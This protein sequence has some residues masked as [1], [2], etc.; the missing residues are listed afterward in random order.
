[1]FGK[2]ERNKNNKSEENVN[3]PDEKSATS[4]I[5][6]EETVNIE[7]LKQKLSVNTDI[8]FN[9][10]IIDADRKFSVVF[11]DGM[12]NSQ[13]V[14]DSILKPLIQEDTLKETE[15]EQDLINLIMLGTVYHCQRKKRD[16]LS[17]CLSD[18]LTGSAV[19]VFEESKTAVTFEIKGFEKRGLSEPTNENVLKGAKE[20]FIEVLR[21]NTA[22]V[23]RRIPTSSL[24]IKQMSI[25]KRTNTA[26]SII[27]LDGLANQS[28]VD[29]VKKRLEKIDID[30]IVSPGVVESYLIDKKTSLFPQ[31]LY[32][33]RADK[34][35]ANIMEGRVGIMIDGFPLAMIEPVDINSFIQAPEDYSQN[36]IYSSLY[37][38]MRYFCFSISLVLPAFY[39]SITTFHQQMIPPK[40]AAAIIQS[41]EGIPLPSFLEVILMLIAFEVLLEAGM[42]LPKSVGQA[43]S[44]VGAL[45]VGQ[46][47]ISA[48]MLSPGVVIVVAAAGIMGFVIPSQDFAN[49][50]RVCRLILVGFS[51]TSG[52]YGLSI[53][54]ILILYHLADM[55]IFGVPYLSPFVSN[56]GKGI[57]NDTLFRIPW[58]KMK[59]RPA[60]I[61]PQDQ[62]RQA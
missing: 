55:E 37:R 58:R 15:T 11:V 43:V 17:D 21:I 28:V 34:F 2:S 50:L 8:I 59:E 13:L 19:L 1:M 30:G 23:R 42:R 32:T 14:D 60:N 12:V 16:K 5:E 36:F 41:K 46:A 26:V 6:P 4:E 61:G 7:A 22:L 40:L 53:G 31:I 56:E 49:S 20:A 45:V 27:Y 54:V 29:E 35:C 52:L 48:K 47:A 9:E 33:E 39:V 62:D 3:P 18:L 10:V 44:I 51:I 57:L 38:I 24:I 25:G